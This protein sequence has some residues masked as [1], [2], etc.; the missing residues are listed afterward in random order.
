MGDNGS[1][2]DDIFEVRMA[3]QTILTSSV[4]V[5]AIS[6]TVTLAVAQHEVQMVGRAAPDGIGTYYI[7]FAGATVV[8]GDPTTGTDLTPGV[9]KTFIIQAQP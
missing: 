7:T 3:G 6:T 2:N 4:P 8:G 5:R 9:V 1:L